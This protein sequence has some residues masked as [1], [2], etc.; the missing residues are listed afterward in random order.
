MKHEFV[1][2]IRG[3]VAYWPTAG[4]AGEVVAL[5]QAR[6]PQAR[7]VAYTLGFAVQTKEFGPYLDRWGQIPTLNEKETTGAP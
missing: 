1:C 6:Y 3:G 4:R 7:V 5:V 2:L